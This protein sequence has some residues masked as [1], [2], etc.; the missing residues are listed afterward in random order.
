MIEPI[1]DHWAIALG[2][3]VLALA[4]ITWWQRRS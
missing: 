4:V 3:V 1:R 2:I